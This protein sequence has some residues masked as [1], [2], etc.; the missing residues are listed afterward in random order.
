MTGLRPYELKI[1]P[2]A[3]VRL[4]NKMRFSKKGLRYFAWKE[5]VLL[6]ALSAKIPAD[7]DELHCKF[8]IRMPD[9]WSEKKRVSLDGSPHQQ[10]PDRNN[11]EKAVEDALWPKRDSHIWKSSA[12]KV[13]GREGKII[14]YA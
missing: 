11:L 7:I 3:A 9:S 4:P 13:W 1:A 5:N 14:I 6:L 8:I 10:T 12:S 2:M